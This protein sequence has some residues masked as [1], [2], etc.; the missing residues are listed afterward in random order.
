LYIS[1]HGKIRAVESPAIKAE[2]SENKVD[3]LLN[4]DEEVESSEV[5]PQFSLAASMARRYQRKK[6]C[7]YLVPDERVFT[8]NLSYPIQALENIDNVLRYDLE[9]HIPLS[10]P[11]VR[12]FYAL[13]ISA[14]RKMV[15]VDTVVIKA[16]DYDALQQV[17][18]DS[19]GHAVVC[20]SKNF[21][22]KY[23]LRINFLDRKSAEDEQ[24]WITWK[25]LHAAFNFALLLILLALPYYLYQ[26]AFDAIESKSKKEVQKVS[27]IVSTINRLNSETD[28]GSKLAV[29]FTPQ[30]RMVY[31]LAQL[32]E[33]IDSDAWITRFSYE[34][35]EIKVKGEAAS[36]TTVSD[37]LN[38]T[39]LFENIKFVS[40][41]V[42]N[43]K[44]GKESFELSLRVKPDA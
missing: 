36:A 19:H 29:E 38:Q 34:N 33:H 2:N 25:N 26:N 18:D 16:D 20:T 21:Y 44:T 37:S 39:G 10:I 15:N 14:D 42:K 17:F 1:E 5:D 35:G 11:E 3:F 30:Q 12:F 24:S 8:V 6:R 7:L 28:L 23:G 40:S 27:S 41:I 43:P 13:N 4:E 32:S 9:K 22:K 31:L